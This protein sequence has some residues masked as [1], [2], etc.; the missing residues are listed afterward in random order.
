MRV[1]PDGTGMHVPVGEIAP[2][3]RVRIAV[4]ERIPVDATILEGASDVDRSLLT[5]EAEP[6]AIGVGGHVF[7]GTLNLTGPLLV[8][9]TAKSGDTLLADIA[10]LMEAAERSGSRFVRIADRASRIYAP[11]VHIL[12]AAT[13]LGWL[14]AG[15]GWHEALMACVAVLIITCP[16]ALAL[17][18][19]AVQVAASSRLFAA[20]VIVKASDA[21]ERLA[22]IDTVVFDKTG[23]LTQG[24]PRLIGAESVDVVA[25]QRAACVA[26]HSR[27]PLSKALVKAAEA[28]GLVLRHLESVEEIPG[29]G[30]VATSAQGEERLGSAAWVRA[31][32]CNAPTTLWYRRGA[33]AP[34]PF[35]FEDALRADAAT[36]VADLHRAG[37]AV[38]LLSGDTE[39]AARAAAVAAG[40][41][42]FQGRVRPD[43]K[44]ARLAALQAQGRKVL[45]IGDGLNDAPAL[46][47]GYA[48]LSPSTAADISQTAAGAVFQGER[49][50]PVV[51]TIAVAQAARAM[52]LQNFAIAL[53]YNAFFVPLAMAGLVTPLLAALAMSL[54]SVAVTGNAL[55]L[56]TKRLALGSV[57]AAEKRT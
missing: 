22:E 9:V 54:S 52:S 7:A 1:E 27:H 10:R 34:V 19:P 37:Y 12:A 53:A 57:P 40:I 23:T 14:L 17:A 29:S 25:L 5:G 42:T 28:R 26:L 4:G 21:L 41:R 11:A 35:H 46:A 2:G 33:E 15:A 30:L 6:E 3:D 43:G 51:E 8:E 18:V 31:S 16:C 13:L 24:E 45:M 55:R 44:I 49:L 36:V 32:E 38:E 48:S 50:A 20:G 47:A 56:R 39:P